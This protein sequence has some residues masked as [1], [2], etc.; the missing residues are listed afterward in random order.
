[1]AKAY[2]QLEMMGV[3]DTEQGS[4]AFIRPTRGSLLSK[5]DKAPH[6]E[7]LCRDFAGPAQLQNLTLEEG[8]RLPPGDAERVG[9]DGKERMTMPTS[10][11]GDSPIE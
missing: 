7:A 3:L 8:H 11:E 9:D 5:E 1:M 10:S 6:L 2:S 4:G